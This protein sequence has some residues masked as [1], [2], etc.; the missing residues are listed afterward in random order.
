MRTSAG[1]PDPPPAVAPR[2]SASATTSADITGPPPWV[3]YPT[4]LEGRWVAGKGPGRV[5]LVVSNA[6]FDVLK[7]VGQ[8]Q[9]HP[10]LHRTMVVFGDQVLLRT[11]GDR[12][13]VSTYRWRVAGDRLTF[14]LVRQTPGVRL[15]LAGLT[16]RSAA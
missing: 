14:E 15:G 5:A 4:R 12:D 2:G 11:P 16:F 10:A 7:E 6:S 13:D 3:R 1:Q 8:R 9:G